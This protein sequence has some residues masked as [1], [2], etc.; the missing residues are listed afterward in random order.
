MP[1][2][3]DD[4]R[5]RSGNAPK[6][7]APRR[8][9]DRSERPR[10]DE[11]P[12]PRGPRRPIKGKRR[13]FDTDSAPNERERARLDRRDDAD[14]A[15]EADACAA[16]SGRDEWVDE[17]P[18]RR[19]AGDAVRRGSAAKPGERR[20]N[21]QRSGTE[22]PAPS[23][24]DKRRKERATK[25]A[26]SAMELD[27]DKLTR[28]F[29]AAR[30]DRTIRRLGE[31]A[32]A[33]AEERYEDARKLLKPL[34][35]SVPGEPAIREL[36]GLTLYRLGRWRLAIVELQE[37]A[38]RTV[39]AE[40]HPVLADCHRALGQHRKVA[41]LWEELGAASPDAA[42][43]AEGRI[44]YAGSLADRGDLPGAI[45]VLEAGSLGTKKLKHHHL[46]MRY[47]LAD[48]YDRAGEHQSARRHFEAVA[49]ADPGFYDV[50]DRLRQL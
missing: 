3:R 31:A 28:Q 45:A 2:P 32:D 16:G 30:A 37:F 50:G 36:Y 19:A 35:E 5:R 20:P 48:L 42:T 17:G 40:Q 6:R 34:A 24:N 41:E 8:D 27:R 22:R 9:R 43:I 4:D 38:R 26:E 7:G 44:V 12:P 29:G 47:A 15:G 21:R 23:R 1:G 11:G 46:R 14:G 13:T 39:S 18:V 25:R 49:A 33:F 10:R